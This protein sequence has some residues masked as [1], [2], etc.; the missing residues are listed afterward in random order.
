MITFYE[1]ITLPDICTHIFR[2]LTYSDVPLLSNNLEL[3][4][5]YRSRFQQTFFSSSMLFSSSA[6][7]FIFFAAGIRGSCIKWP[8]V[9]A[10][11]HTTVKSACR[12]GGPFT[13][14]FEK[15]EKK[16]IVEAA[17]GEGRETWSGKAARKGATRASPPSVVPV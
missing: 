7:L 9:Y 8:V 15:G 2:N 11:L 10:P 16:T 13:G 14:T 3:F 6:I 12:S 17:T 4:F 5:I 1:P